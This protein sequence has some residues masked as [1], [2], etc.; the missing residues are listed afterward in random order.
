MI[1]E[2]HFIMRQT[3]FFKEYSSL[4]ICLVNFLLFFLITYFMSR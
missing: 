3:S 2:K 4:I 1:Y